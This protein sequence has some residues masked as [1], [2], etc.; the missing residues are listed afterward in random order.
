MDQQIPYQIDCVTHV[1]HV[2]FLAAFPRF[3]NY[4]VTYTLPC[5]ELWYHPSYGY[6]GARLPSHRKDM[7]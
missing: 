5:R 4:F 1:M 2:D 6:L 7:L 3:Q